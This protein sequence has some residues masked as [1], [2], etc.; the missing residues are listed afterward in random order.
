MVTISVDDRKIDAPQGQSLL[1]ACLANGIYIPHLC[2]IKSMA[3]PPA[4]CR[5]CFV[6][7]ENEDSPQLACKTA[8]SPNLVVKTNTPEVRRLQKTAFE[9]LMSCHEINCKPCP[10]NKKCG[11]QDIARFLKIGLK[12]KHLHR[13]LKEPQIDRAHPCLDYYPNRCVLCGKCIHVCRSHNRHTA[14]TFARRGFDTVISFFGTTGP[15]A[16]ACDGCRSCVA[17]CPVGALTVRDA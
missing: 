6:A 10:A 11:L 16:G 14:I 17:V 7:I 9:L 13:R 5:L 8:I 12:P 2:W 15:D 4:S 3:A 1:S